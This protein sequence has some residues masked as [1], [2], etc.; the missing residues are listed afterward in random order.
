[1]KSTDQNKKTDELEQQI[2]ESLSLFFFFL[3]SNGK[4]FS[5][6]L[7]GCKNCKE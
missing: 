4:V 5:P 7:A 6:F 2:R 3:P 1:M